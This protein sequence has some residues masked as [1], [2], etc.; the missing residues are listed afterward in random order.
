MSAPL[1]QTP[2]GHFETA[3]TGVQTS[4]DSLI[5]EFRMLAEE[6]TAAAFSKNQAQIRKL[7]LDLQKLFSSILEF[8]PQTKAQKVAHC[9]FLLDQLILLEQQQLSSKTI[10]KKILQLVV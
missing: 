6:M 3:N 9:D 10:R 1:E 5:S 4:L 8:V 2:K 7:D